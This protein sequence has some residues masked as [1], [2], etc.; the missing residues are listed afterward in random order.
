VDENDKVM[1]QI[2]LLWDAIHALHKQNDFDDDGPLMDQ[3]DDLR[4]RLI[5]LT[6]GVAIPE[7]S[8][9]D[10][11]NLDDAANALQTAINNSQAASD[12]VGL[13]TA[14]ANL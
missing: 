6:P 1:L 9:A 7:L 3:I 12:I 13:A 5:A 2:K 11:K 8:D 10:T 14:V 4:D